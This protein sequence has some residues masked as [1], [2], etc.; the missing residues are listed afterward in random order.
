MTLRASAVAAVGLSLAIASGSLA[1]EWIG[2]AGVGVVVRDEQGQPI[3]GAAVGLFTAAV[4][5][6]R[7]GARVAELETH[8]E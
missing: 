5:A 3:P 8:P 2:S 1:Q 4:F 7:H 6:A